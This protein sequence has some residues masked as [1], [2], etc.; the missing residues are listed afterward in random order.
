M[1]P[2]GAYCDKKYTCL[3]C[4]TLSNERSLTAGDSSVIFD[5]Y[6]PS[7]LTNFALVMRS[8]ND[9]VELADV[10]YPDA[11]NFRSLSGPCD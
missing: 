8:P 7:I 6:S 9:I 10:P 4:V 11:V 1:T 3:H 2:L 5:I